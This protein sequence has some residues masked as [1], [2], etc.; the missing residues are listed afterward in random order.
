MGHGQ[1]HLRRHGVQSHRPHH[2]AAD[3]EDQPQ[4]RPPVRL[5]CHGRAGAQR[6]VRR[7]RVRG[8]G[9]V[10][11]RV[12]T[13]VL[14]HHRQPAALGRE[15]SQAEP[16]R[17]PAAQRRRPGQRQHAGRRWGAARLHQPVWVARGLHRWRL[18]HRRHHARVQWRV[19]SQ[20]RVLRPGRSAPAGDV[21]R[22]GDLRQARAV[23]QVGPGVQQQR[24]GHHPVGGHLH[25]PGLPGPA[26]SPG[27]VHPGFR[28]QGLGRGRLRRVPLE[29]HLRQRQRAPEQVPQRSG[30]HVC[31]G[32]GVQGRHV[33][34]D[35]EAP[36]DSRQ[37]GRRHHGAGPVVARQQLPVPGPGRLQR[38]LLQP[39]R[40]R[41]RLLQ[42]DVPCLVLATLP[43]AVRRGHRRVV[44]RR[45][46]RGE[47][48]A[49]QQPAALQHA[50][51]AV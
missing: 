29:L 19:A 5:R 35:H 32:H 39:A 34:G 6:A 45:G 44:E 30:R 7:G 41:H 25:R 18:R 40:Q 24:V 36:R 8:R 33:D 51:L 13:V 22:R 26:H 49:V 9:E 11:P 38:V 10:Q 46:R 20:R 17:G 16:R 14:R 50:A 15:G 43:D 31:P 42:T 47:R 23:T 21:G 28:L 1:H 27:C 12:R 3:R 48:D 37:G 2:G 4:S